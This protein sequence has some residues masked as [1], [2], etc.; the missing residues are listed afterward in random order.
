M[1]RCDDS[2]LYDVWLGFVRG[3][4]LSV[5]DEIGLFEVLGGRT[6][7]AEALARR[8]KAASA[9]LDALLRV[10]ASEGLVAANGTGFRATESARRYLRRVSPFYWGAALENARQRPEHQ[11]LLQA[12]RTAEPGLVVGGKSV[13]RMWR[14]GELSRDVARKFTRTMHA[15]IFPT[16]SAAAARGLFSRSRA[17]LDIG[18]GSGAFSLA[19]AK[20]HPRL[21]C[22]VFDLPAV[23]T[24][25][26]ENANRMRLGSR[27]LARA[28]NF[29]SEAWP[30][31]HDTVLFSNIFHDWQPDVCEELAAKAYECLPPGGRILVH[32]MLL[33]HD[34][35]GPATPLHFSLLM[36]MN[37]RSQQFTTAELRAIL[38]RAGFSGFSV[39]PTLGYYSMSIAVKSK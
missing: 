36:F 39:R 37:H 34:K 4:A 12:L 22:T 20:R 2:P 21:R 7:S 3:A 1:S 5:A 30:R 27:V 31:D 28:G 15:T 11:R 25:A 32:E 10:L 17:L 26:Q 14:Q 9:G 19:A 23:C 33:N 24:I 13:T 38:K 16:A 35:L 6:L 8:L 18:G 29:F